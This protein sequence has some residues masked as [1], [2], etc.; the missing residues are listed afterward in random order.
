MGC[1]SAALVREFAISSDPVSVSWAR[2]GVVADASAVGVARGARGGIRLSLR[3]IVTRCL[4]GVGAALRPG[5][6]VRKP[7]TSYY[8]H[9]GRRRRGIC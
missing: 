8:S 9:E 3:Q 5:L 7:L 2:L 6:Q 4:G 1:V